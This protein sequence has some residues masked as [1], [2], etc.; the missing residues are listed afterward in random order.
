MKTAIF[1]AFLLL[2]SLCLRAQPGQPPLFDDSKVSFVYIYL[3][4]EDSAA[5]FNDPAAKDEY[6]GTFIFFD[7]VQRD[8]L[9]NIGFRVKGNTSVG[10]YKKSFRVSFNAYKAGQ[11]FGGVEKINLIGSHNDPSM[12]RE[13]L[14]Y[15]MYNRFG[16]PPLRCTF[17]RLFLNDEYRGLY[18]NVEEIDEIFCK[19]RFGNNSGN[20]YKCTYPADLDFLGNNPDAYQA[21]QPWSGG[22]RIYDLQN[23][24]AEDDYSGLAHF[25]QVLTQTQGGTF[26]CEI[27]KVLDIDN[28][29]KAYAIDIATGNWDNY[30]YLKNNYFLYENQFTGKFEFIVYDT[31]N[32][33]GV[34]WIGG[35]DWAT[36]NIYTW[37]NTGEVRP[38]VSR[39]INVPAFRDRLSFYLRELADGIMQPAYINLHIDSMKALITDAA[40][41]DNYRTLDYG[42]TINDFLT[43]FNN[44]NIDGHTPYGVK[45]FIAAR[46][47]N[48]LSQLNLGNI[49]PIADEVVH[50]PLAPSATDSIHVKLPVTDDNFV[51]TVK[52]FY[53]TDST[54]FQALNLA[55]DGL[56]DDGLSGDG[57]WGVVAPPAGSASRWYFH[58]E[59]TDNT[60]QTARLPICGENSI[61]LGRWP[62]P[63]FINEIM[64]KNTSVIA[65]NAGEFEDYVEI[66]N[67]GAE[68][69]ALGDLYMSD[70]FTHPDRWRL[71]DI[72]LAPGAWKLFWLDNDPDQGSDHA[73]FKLD[74]N[75]EQI[76]LFGPASAYYAAIDS[77]SFGPQA[78]NMSIGYLPDGEGSIVDLPYPSPGYTN[79]PNSVPTDSGTQ[80]IVFPNPSSGRYTLQFGL[81]SPGNVSIEILDVMGRQIT[82]TTWRDRSAGLQNIPFDIPFAPAGVYLLQVRTEGKTM[83]RK[84]LKK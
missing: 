34:N 80:V 36:R 27:E 25:V 41:E 81:Q 29:L 83:I 47:D 16:L 55:D 9:E 72:S 67:A 77:F 39:L 56:H 82:S 64:A 75:G 58:I 32:T 13:K 1:S 46:R 3:S 61:R 42:Y 73:D 50:A 40:I 84:L 15:D 24:K 4:P 79:V 44:D 12:I 8:T 23:N 28:F 70:D 63:L 57:T 66:Y 53:S 76:G 48:I 69:V 60:G 38:L 37:Y 49:F 78:E 14:Y 6:P 35:V 30:A 2:A 54:N 71:P 21:T 22:D 7:G 19:N 59:A 51:A 45:N 11:K 26:P 33:C 5:M 10:A 62:L 31:D 74:A 52:L 65:D 17:V 68:P 20:L 43:S 18:T